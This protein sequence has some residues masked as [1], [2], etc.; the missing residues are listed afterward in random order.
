MNK[1]IITLLIFTF[2]PT[3]VY[4]SIGYYTRDEKGV[5][6][7]KIH[8][9][10]SSYEPSKDVA[11]TR[12]AKKTVYANKLDMKYHKEGCR[13]SRRTANRMTVEEAIELGYQPCQKCRP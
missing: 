2:L 9:E 6:Y 4:A 10:D 12:E 11:G 7:Y 3:A 8:D 5:M 13:Y 1:L